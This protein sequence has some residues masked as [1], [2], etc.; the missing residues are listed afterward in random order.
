MLL[1]WEQKVARSVSDLS[2]AYLAISNSMSSIFKNMVNEIHRIENECS[3]VILLNF[4]RTS[5]IM[6]KYG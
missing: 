2:D 5:N 1:E 6:K 3:K 4:T